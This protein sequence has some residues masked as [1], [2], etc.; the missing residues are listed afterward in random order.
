MRSVLLAVLVLMP[1][2]C[3]AQIFRNAPWNRGV[4][5]SSGCPGGI[6]PTGTPTRAAT[7]S[8]ASAGHWSYPGTIDSHLQSTHGVSTAGMTREQML[9]TH[10]ALHEGRSIQRPVQSAPAVIRVTPQPVYQPIRP[11]LAPPIRSQSIIEPQSSAPTFGLGEPSQDDLTDLNIPPYIL[12]QIAEP[13]AVK[14]QQV[15]GK[16][17]FRINLSKAIVE[18]R[19]AGKI[20]T[21]DA[22]RL[23]VAMLSPAF[24]DRAMDLAVAQ[25]A[26][27]GDVADAVPVDDEGV[28]QV[29]GI[30][31]AGLAKFLEALVPL[32]LT[33]LKAF[34]M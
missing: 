19:K 6:C 4:Q 16:E 3:E 22:V 20:T 32:L 5:R 15:S 9:N 26:F 13:E 17:G 27:S 18:Q 31:W 24:Q 10:D 1:T 29:D 21:R 7:V 30:N 34:G 14:P 23:R 25:V 28:V 33:L 12:A 8:R 2:V 11:T